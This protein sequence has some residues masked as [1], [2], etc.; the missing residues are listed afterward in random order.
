MSLNWVAYWLT[1]YG[2][3]IK[4]LF[5][6]YFLSCIWFFTCISFLNKINWLSLLILISTFSD[7]WRNIELLCHKSI[8]LS[9]V[10]IALEPFWRVLQNFIWTIITTE[11]SI[12]LKL[13]LELST[14]PS[15]LPLGLWLLPLSE[16]SPLESCWQSLRPLGLASRWQ[17]PQQFRHRCNRQQTWR[18]GENMDGY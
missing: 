9:H 11:D 2:Q 12:F 1:C 10:R 3:Q 4:I 6:L 8:R 13:W 7:C 15:K 14:L 18:C 17:L 16:F 5:G